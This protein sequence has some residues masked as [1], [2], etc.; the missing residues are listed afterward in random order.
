MPELPEVEIV[1]CGLEIIFQ[2]QPNIERIECLR[3]DLRTP[4]PVKQLKQI[5]Q[6][7][8]LQVNRRAKYLLIKCDQ[9]TIVSHLGMTGTWRLVDRGQEKKHD[10]VYIYLKGGQRLA[11]HDPRRFGEFAILNDKMKQKF[12]LLGPEP[13]DPNTDWDI[14]YSQIRDKQCA[15]KI[16]IMD[17]KLLVGVGNIYASEALFRAGISPKRKCTTVK[18]SEWNHLIQAIQEVLREAIKAGGSSISDFAQTSGGQG[19]F[20]NQFRVYER[21]NQPCF[22][23]TGSLRKIIL[24][25]RSTFYCSKCQH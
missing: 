2:Q 6:L 24:G 22:N 18:K 5:K 10:H 3:N 9:F 14:L 16:A 4:M 23:C 8:V 21:E 15:I 17:Q 19:Y 7:S 13:L 25:G 12:D 20:Q 11:Y 1:R